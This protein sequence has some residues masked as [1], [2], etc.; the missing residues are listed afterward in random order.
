MHDSNTPSTQEPRRW[1]RMGLKGWLLAGL[2]IL[3]VLW[4]PRPVWEKVATRLM[5]PY[6][7]AWLS[8]TV[9]L[10]A[11][12]RLGPRTHQGLLLLGWLLLTLGGNGY[13]AKSWHRAQEQHY[14]TP[15]PL[16]QGPFES[17]VLLGGGAS[18]GPDGRSQ[19]AI[20]GDRVMLAARLYHAGR[21]QRIICTGSRI[22]G[23]DR[24]HRDQAEV[25]ADLLRGV[26]IPDDCLETVGGRHTAEEMAILGERLAGETRVGLITSAFHMPRAM[27]LAR[28]Q[29]WE[30]VPLPC[31]F[32]TPPDMRPNLLDALPDAYESYLIGLKV[33]EWLAALVSR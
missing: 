17:V 10:L 33:K 13:V 2:A 21:T 11:G 30:P 8:L 24:S 25:A 19:L 28:E 23:L 26:G 15:L 1:P 7:L 32:R 6:S 4:F 20:S 22:A 31:D 12:R 27:R 14:V 9:L 29:G 16:E 5:L 3:A 18:I